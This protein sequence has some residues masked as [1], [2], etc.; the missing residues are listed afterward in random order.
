MHFLNTPLLTRSSKLFVFK[1]FLGV[2]VRLERVIKQLNSVFLNENTW[3][4]RERRGNLGKSRSRVTR[5]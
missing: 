3:M 5:L 4:G 2:D 1:S